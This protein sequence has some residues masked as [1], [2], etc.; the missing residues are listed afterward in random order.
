LRG[1]ESG[2]FRFRSLG[3]GGLRAGNLGGGGSLGVRCA[4]GGL[5]TH[6][7]PGDEYGAHDQHQEA[8]R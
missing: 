2:T 7:E 8:E 6:D 1:F 4:S 3:A 5:G